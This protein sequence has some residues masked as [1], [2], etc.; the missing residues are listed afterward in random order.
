VATVYT[1]EGTEDAVLERVAQ[2]LPE[3]YAARVTGQATRRLTADAG[4]FVAV[5]GSVLGAGEVRFIADAGCRNEEG[6]VEPAEPTSADADRAAVEAVLSTLGA[7]AAEWRTH[8][9]PGPSGD[10]L[11]TV[12]AV[13]AGQAADGSV[14]RALRDTL[15]ETAVIARPDLYAFRNGP[16]GLVA[17]NDGGR[18]VVSATT[19]CQ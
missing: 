13:A 4:N 19:D 18:L 3:R 8:R 6:P 14:E 17:R 5:N 2:A 12:E 10:P 1:P 16:V 9:V 15:G 7:R 11:W